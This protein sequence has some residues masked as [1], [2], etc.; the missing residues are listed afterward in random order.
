M[1]PTRT[2]TPSAP[3]SNTCS[4]RIEYQYYNF[5][6]TTFTGGPAPIVGSRFRDDEHTVK[7][8]VNYRFGWGG[9]PVAAKY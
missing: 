8:G 4:R 2:A 7:V 9:A 5:G 1:A 3:V 6:S